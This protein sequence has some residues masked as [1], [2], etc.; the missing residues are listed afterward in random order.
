MKKY[1]TGADMKKLENKKGVILEES[2]DLVLVKTD[3]IFTVWIPED[4]LHFV[5]TFYEEEARQTFEKYKRA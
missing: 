3:D 4:N 2:G 5:N 1:V